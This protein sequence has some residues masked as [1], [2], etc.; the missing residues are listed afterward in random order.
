MRLH[1]T[2]FVAGGDTLAGRAIVQ[3]LRQSGYTRVVGDIQHDGTPGGEPFKSPN[4]FNRDQLEAYF[5]HHS[6]QYVVHAAGKS[7][8]IGANST[9]PA[10]LCAQNM[11]IDL[12][13]I[14]TARKFGVARFVYL[15]S[16]CCYPVAA[17]QPVKPEAMW[18]GPLEPTSQ[19]YAAAKLAGVALCQAVRQQSG[20]DF[21][22][23]VPTT[24]FGPGDHADEQLGHVIP[25]LMQ[26]FRKACDQNLP[27]IEIWG[28]GAPVREF[29]A[30]DD[31]AAACVT[32]LQ[33]AHPPQIVNLGS[34][35]TLSIADLVQTLIQITGYQGRV[36]FNSQLPDGA[37]HK[38]LDST[39]LLQT[40]WRPSQSLRDWLQLTY[41]SLQRAAADT[42]ALPAGN[43]KASQA[44]SIETPSVLTDEPI[45]LSIVGMPA[46]A[47]TLD[48]ELYRELYRIRRV[49]EEIAKVYPTDRIQSPVHLSIGQ[50][51]I[52]VAVC[53]ALRPEDVAFG[54]YRSHAYYL[55]KG[56]DLRGMIAEL[57]GKATGVAKGKAGSMHLI[58]TAAGVMGA[59]AIV[60][61][62]LPQAVGY[63][64]GIQTAGESRVVVAFCGEG[65]TEEGVFAESLNFAALKQLPILFVCE[66][67][68][69]AIH[70]KQSDRQA[71]TD[72]T[73]R[74]KAFGLTSR[75][76]P[77]MDVYELYA[78]SCAAVESL[79]EGS[80]PIF[81]ECCCYRWMEHVGPHQDFAAGYR[82]QREA[83]PW[84]EDD[85]LSLVAAKL[86]EKTRRQIELH[87]EK[88]IHDAFTF[89]ENSPVPEISE[90]HTDLYA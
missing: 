18:T 38:E 30:A 8:G 16:S 7:G 13:L 35:Q 46:E 9:S 76:F 27:E 36:V 78:A 33:H 88:E 90:L 23:A 71:T 3:R 47:H 67:N 68:A 59:S 17:A 60:A 89:A 2:I 53:Q 42:I 39:W 74:A 5:R 49:E 61:S 6:P 51:A 21:I 84:I 44:T 55:A 85:A 64:L 48:N 52:S 19:A 87:V 66:N 11:A 1:D 83:Q 4:L 82:C 32:L 15:A 37:P 40:G 77:Q 34:G 56:G 81:F 73:A 70:S 62:T 80:G 41:D 75:R 12:N 26:R 69:Y 79:R 50:E 22:V 65:A 45:D 28:T 58:D 25:A 29:I 14:D 54:S 63:A 20:R 86:T 72:I 43:S 10:D 24:V 31:L 57:Y